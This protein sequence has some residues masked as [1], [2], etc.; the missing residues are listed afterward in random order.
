MFN[1]NN[2]ERKILL[3]VVF[4]FSFSLLAGR[5]YRA[6]AVFFPAVKTSAEIFPVNVNS[7]DFNQLVNVP[8]IGPA[9]AEKI[10]ARRR[11]K[12]FKSLDEL[13]QIKGIKDKKLNKI[14]PYLR[15]D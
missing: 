2:Q 3:A 5:L 7:A 11:E 9:L 12:P 15:L 1:L 14:K 13:K 6:K 8:G 4:F 10:I